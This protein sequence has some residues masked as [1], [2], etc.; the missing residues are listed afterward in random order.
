MLPGVAGGTNV[1]VGVGGTRGV[2]EGVSVLPGV[3]D[4]VGVMVGVVRHEVRQEA[5]RIGFETFDPA[6]LRQ[7]LRLSSG[8]IKISS[9]ADF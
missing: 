3:G 6:V 4:G 1:L 7:R 2:G 9:S 5:A 8:S